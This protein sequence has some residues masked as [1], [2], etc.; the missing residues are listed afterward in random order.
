MLTYILFFTLQGMSCDRLCTS[1][2]VLWLGDCLSVLIWTLVLPTCPSAD[3]FN[4]DLVS[5]IKSVHTSETGYCQFRFTTSPVCICRPLSFLSCWHIRWL[6][7]CW[8]NTAN[9]S[10]VFPDLRLCLK[11]FDNQT[12]SAADCWFSAYTNDT[13]SFWIL[14]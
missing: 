8:Q 7:S 10:Q 13:P 12:H 3:K 11:A 9:I 6:E 2:A 4:D 5:C 1:S 14:W